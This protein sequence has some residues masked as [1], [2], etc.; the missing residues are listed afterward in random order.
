MSNPDITKIRKFHPER[1]GV[2]GS[3]KDSGA[4]LDAT[5]E[6]LEDLIE[7]AKVELKEVNKKIEAQEAEQYEDN[8]VAQLK[9]IAKE[10]EIDLGDATTKAAIIEVIVAEDNK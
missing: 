8:T 1:F 6:A 10:R 9:D 7:K 2:L 5:K 4:P 3:L